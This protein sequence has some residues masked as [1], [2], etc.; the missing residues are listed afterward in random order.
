MK[1]NPKI[2][3]TESIVWSFL[4]NERIYEGQPAK[5]LIFTPIVYK[6]Y[7]TNFADKAGTIYQNRI[8]VRFPQGGM[9]CM[10]LRGKAPLHKEFTLDDF[11]N[12]FYMILDE[13][14]GTPYFKYYKK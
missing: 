4:H 11:V 8:M 1:R 13:K 7:Y 14:T 12:S 5:E 3:L 10:R 9:C 6:C 2:R